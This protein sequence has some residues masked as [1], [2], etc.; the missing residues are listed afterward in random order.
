[1]DQFGPER[2]KLRLNHGVREGGPDGL[3]K[4]L[5]PVH[6]SDEHVL[7]AAVLEFV[8]HRE[9]ELRPLVLGDPFV[10]KT[11]HWGLF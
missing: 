6:N 1:V 2:A 4:A 11:P 7:Q 9:P 8:H 5:Q 10:G 3:W